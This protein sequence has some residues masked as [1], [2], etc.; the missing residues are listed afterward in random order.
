MANVCLAR[1]PLSGRDDFLV[2]RLVHRMCGVCPIKPR[3]EPGACSIAFPRSLS[4]Y[5]PHLLNRLHLGIRR[6]VKVFH[7]EK[8]IRVLCWN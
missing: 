8:A 7:A 1:R 6:T 4:V 2:Q 5:H 3:P